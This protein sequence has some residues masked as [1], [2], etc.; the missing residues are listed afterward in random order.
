MEYMNT[1]LTPAEDNV[2]GTAGDAKAQSTL[3]KYLHK[4]RYGELKEHLPKL[5]NGVTDGETEEL[6]DVL[7]HH[8]FR[9]GNDPVPDDQKPWFQVAS[10][11]CSMGQS[12][13]ISSGVFNCYPKPGLITDEV[14]C[15]A[16]MHNS[17]GIGWYDDEKETACTAVC[18]TACRSA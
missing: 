17:L 2:H 14:F 12:G 13:G 8:R 3:T 6:G 9:D 18:I 15:H 4:K 11:R 7:Y 5:P 1:Y 10:M 16:V